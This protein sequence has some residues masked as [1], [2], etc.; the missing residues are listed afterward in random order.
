MPYR[1]ALMLACLSVLILF[2]PQTLAQDEKSDPFWRHFDERYPEI[3]GKGQELWDKAAEIAEFQVGDGDEDAFA[4]RQNL[5]FQAM[6][7]N[8]RDQAIMRKRAKTKE[9]HDYILSR[10]DAA[11]QFKKDVE[12]I[13]AIRAKPDE[14]ITQAEVKRLLDACVSLM[15]YIYEAQI[16]A[17]EAYFESVIRE[18]SE[19]EDKLAEAEKK[20]APQP[21]AQE[22]ESK[23]SGSSR[24]AKKGDFKAYLQTNRIRIDSDDR[25]HDYDRNHVQITG[26]IKNQTDKPARFNFQVFGLRSDKTVVGLKT[27]TTPVIAPGAV[28]EIDA[29]MGVEHSA[30]VRSVDMRGVMVIE[31]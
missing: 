31:P 19:L 22:T 29:R 23:P 27:I 3:A 5:V 16:Q 26:A 21:V 24:K 25:R 4:T 17:N 9:E 18:N 6:A 11:R 14:E 20:P 12:T 28:H 2:G 15:Q 10:R 13:E 7:V 1:L 8:E 30:Y